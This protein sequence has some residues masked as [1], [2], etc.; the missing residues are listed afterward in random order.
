MKR[1][2]TPSRSFLCLRHGVTDWN[3]QGRFQ[4]RTDNPLND[5]G[6]SQAQAAAD[7]LCKLSFD[8][9]RPLARA[10][11]TEVSPWRPASRSTSMTA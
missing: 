11:Q 6:I 5:E 10:R 4:G 1:L 8:L 9:V 2:A 7:R 3:A